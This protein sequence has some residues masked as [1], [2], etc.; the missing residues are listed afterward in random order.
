[1]WENELPSLEETSRQLYSCKKLEVKTETQILVEAGNGQSDCEEIEA[2]GKLAYNKLRVP[3]RAPK[4]P[5]GKPVVKA[6]K[7][8]QGPV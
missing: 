1:M 3:E 6:G 2:M 4:C 7:E 5:E 8:R